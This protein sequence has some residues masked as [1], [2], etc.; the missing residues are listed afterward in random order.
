[1]SVFELAC[2]LSLCHQAYEAT[3]GEQGISPT[4]YR[5]L[6]AC[7][8]W[9]TLAYAGFSLCFAVSPIAVSDQGSSTVMAIHTVPFIFL[10]LANWSHALTDLWYESASGY[11]KHLEMPCIFNAKV[12]L[13]YVVALSVTTIGALHLP[14]SCWYIWHSC[15][16]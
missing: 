3:N 12:G 5:V 8:I 16:Q 1:M 2:A 15:P 13:A 9:E 14:Q 11:L 6:R 10:E 4:S 7:C